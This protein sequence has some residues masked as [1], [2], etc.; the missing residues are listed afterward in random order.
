VSTVNGGLMYAPG[1]ISFV[2]VEASSGLHVGSSFDFYWG[3][4]VG[5]SF[6]VSN[7]LSATFRLCQATLRASHCWIKSLCSVFW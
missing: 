5:V 3:S 7:P 6:L 1:L 4:L 2:E